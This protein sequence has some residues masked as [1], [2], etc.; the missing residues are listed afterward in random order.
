MAIDANSRQR[1]LA[2]RS[3]SIKKLLIGLA[4]CLWLILPS[5]MA[6]GHPCPEQTDANKN[7]CDDRLTME[8]DLG[9]R[10]ARFLPQGSRYS[11]LARH[12]VRLGLYQH[13]CTESFNKPIHLPVRDS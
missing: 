6:S 11:S 2:A 3:H 9:T 10:P 7:F 12:T 13:K 1:S 5:Y 8:I 4:S